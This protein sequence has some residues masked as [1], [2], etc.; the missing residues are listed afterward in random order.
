MSATG[1]SAA[2]APVKLWRLAGRIYHEAIY[3]GSLSAAGSST[4]RLLER[5]TKQSRYITR[6]ALMIQILSSFYLLIVTFLPAVTMA[7]LSGGATHQWNLFVTT[8]AGTTHLFVQTGYLM[9][10]TL[11]ATSEILAPDLYRWPESLPLRPE[12][13]GSLRVMALAREFL[14]PLSVI[15]VSYPV[16]AAIASGGLG[17]AVATLFVS[18]IHAVMTLSVIVLASWRLRRTLRLA[19]GNDRRATT[20]RVLTMA[21]Y[22][23]GIIV[24]VAV[25]QFGMNF[26]ASL[27]DDPRMTEV[28]SLSIL[29]VIS[30]LPF[31]TSAASFVSALVARRA[32]LPSALPLWIPFLG[33]CL[34]GGGALLLLR[35]AW[36]L[37][38]RRDT[39]GDVHPRTVEPLSRAGDQDSASTTLSAPL[40]V[41]TPRAAFRR[42]LFQAATRDTGVLLALLFPLVIPVATLTGP[43]VSGVPINILLYGGPIMAAVM[44]GWL[45]VHGLTRLQVGTGLMEASLPLVERDRAFPRLT[46]C[47]IIPAAGVVIAG[48]VL[49]PSGLRLE[50]FLLSTIPVIAVPVGFLVKTSLFGRIRSS[51]PGRGFTTRVVVEEVY[52]DHRFFKWVGAITAVL[53]VAG[54]FI[55]LRIVL[56]KVIPGPIGTGIYLA[57][58]A[59]AALILRFTAGRVFPAAAP[60]R[61]RHQ[62]EPEDR[63]QSGDRPEATAGR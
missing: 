33:T 7:Q 48:L 2:I 15:V 30:V 18:A 51:K 12:Q 37:I 14:L 17:V 63:P 49:L 61:D 26:V 58:A 3:Q 25:M 35:S 31:P 10:L 34:Y 55:A 11:V 23:I 1:S 54:G 56:T 47:A 24:V 40:V 5:M 60:P 41:R 29:R 27:F 21:G 38:G 52:I 45:L 46:L 36:R 43:K 39:D 32:A 44:G 8:L 13:A 4:Q 6:Q 28:K 16:A 42:Q 59:L 50:V 57:A 53:I 9:V 19:S 22:G 62:G 20:V